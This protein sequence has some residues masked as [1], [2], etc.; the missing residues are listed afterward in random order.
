[1]RENCVLQCG[2][3]FAGAIAKRFDSFSNN[4]LRILGIFL[5]IG[6]D[7]LDGHRVMTLVPAVIIGHHG[8]GDVEISASRASFASCRLV[9][10]MMS[11][12]QERYTLDSARVEKAG[13]SI[14][15]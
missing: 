11:I 13:P 9:I 3:A 7:L 10:P 1:M 8:Q 14:H 5:Q 12:P 4:L 2:A 6:N 15:R